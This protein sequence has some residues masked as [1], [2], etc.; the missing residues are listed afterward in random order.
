M[1]AELPTPHDT[2]FRALFS[3][4]ERVRDFLRD[5]LPNSISGLMADTLPEIVEGSFVDEALA[6]SQ[7]DLLL[8]VELASGRDA[9]YMSSRTQKYA[10]TR[11]SPPA[12][13]LYGEDLETVRGHVGVQAPFAAT[14]RAGRRLPWRGRLDGAESL[15]GMI[16]TDDP[17]LAFL[18][19][20][21]Y[22]LRNLRAMDIDALSTNAALRAGF[23]ALRREALGFLAEVAE[24]LP[25]HGDLRRQVLEYVLRVYSVDLGNSGL[26]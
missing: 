22:I 13:L 23:I 5:H 17:D 12:G 6:G 15:H 10:R 3:D 24:S 14:D 7:S 26:C 11:P 18:P 8:K 25:A 16:A 2:F 21:G 9:L 19:G 4:R 1:M 20:S